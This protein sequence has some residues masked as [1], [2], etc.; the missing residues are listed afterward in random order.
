MRVAS[1][2]AGSAGSP[3]ATATSR[4]ASPEVL[5][6]LAEGESARAVEVRW[7][8]GAVTRIEEPPTG[9]YLKIDP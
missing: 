9:A 8:D 7:P 1:R 6:A 5:F 4:P 3:P 2:S